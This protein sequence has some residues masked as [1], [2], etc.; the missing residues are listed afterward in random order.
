MLHASL[1]AMADAGLRPHDIDGVMTPI[2]G[3]SAED[4]AVN[5]G[6]ENLRYARR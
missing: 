2:W 3:A 6:I 1:A 4:V 5:L